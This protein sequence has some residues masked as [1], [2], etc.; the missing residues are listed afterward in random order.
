MIFNIWPFL[1]CCF[2]VTSN[3]NTIVSAAKSQIFPLRYYFQTSNEYY[4][5]AVNILRSFNKNPICIESSDVKNL[6]SPSFGDIKKYQPKLI[7]RSKLEKRAKDFQCSFCVMAKS[8]LLYMENLIKK[9]NNGEPFVHDEKTMKRLELEAKVLLEILR[10]ENLQTGKWL[11]I[12]L[13]K[14]IA[15]RQYNANKTIFR[16][17]PI[18]DNELQNGVSNF[19][20]NCVIEKYLL[21]IPLPDLISKN[22][23]I[24]N[25]MMYDLLVAKWVLHNSD[26]VT[27]EFL[28]LKRFWDDGEQ[29]L[30]RPITEVNVDWSEAKRRHGVEVA[31]TKVFVE[32]RGWILKPYGRFEHQQLLVEIIDARIYCY[33]SVILYVYEKQLFTFDER[34]RSEIKYLIVNHILD[35]LTLTAFKDDFLVD[36]LAEL[37]FAKTLSID[38]I[39]AISAKVKAKANDILNLLN[40]VHTNEIGWLSFNV[41]EDQLSTDDFIR[42]AVRNFKFYLTDFKQFLPFEYSVLL[43]FMNAA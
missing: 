5:R 6:T 16:K 43:H 40:G 21:P 35:A 8:N 4:V 36:T 34:T 20:A 26:F 42:E 39:K 29:I 7:S 13:L 10:A 33:L 15:I 12:Y 23:T 32:N 22:P 17:N 18:I 27:V 24:V 19:I 11:W 41:N 2:A 30:F 25:T 38:E 14:I 28:Y 37:E 31:A 1:L 9:L 3:L